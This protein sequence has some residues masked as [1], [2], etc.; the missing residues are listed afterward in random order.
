MMRADHQ[1][2]AD[3]HEVALA[4]GATVSLHRDGAAGRL[5]VSGELDIASAP[6]LFDAIGHVGAGCRAVTIDLRAVA[7]IDVA[8]LRALLAL[9]ERLRGARLTVLPGAACARLL[10]LTGTAALVPP[11]LPDPPRAP[12]AR[13]PRG[14]IRAAS[15]RACVP[16]PAPPRHA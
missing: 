5:S 15:A 3:P 11:A 7:F 6:G 16:A 4:P 14:R 1:R 2:G 8:G 10:E 9:C 12:L 13:T